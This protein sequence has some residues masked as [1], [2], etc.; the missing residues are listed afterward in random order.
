MLWECRESALVVRLPR[1]IEGD[2]V[3]P[4]HGFPPDRCLC[5]IQPSYEDKHVHLKWFSASALHSTPHFRGEVRSCAPTGCST[6]PQRL[7]HHTLA[8]QVAAKF[9][10]KGLRR[11]AVLPSQ[12]GWPG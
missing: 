8:W 10:I 5:E 11:T 4:R 3:H 1:V 12:V 9:G 6:I 2:M 7:A